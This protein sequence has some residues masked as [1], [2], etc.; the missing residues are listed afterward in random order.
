[1]SITQ[2][3]RN[4]LGTAIVL[5]SSLGIG[6]SSYTEEPSDAINLSE[7]S[8][9]KGKKVIIEALPGQDE[10]GVLYLSDGQNG[11]NILRDEWAGN[12]NGDSDLGMEAIQREVNDGIER[13]IE[14]WGI[15]SDDGLAIKARTAKVY[16]QDKERFV[17]YEVYK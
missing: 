13:K 5:A 3:L 2:R 14:V 11:L 1:M 6:C 9:Y 4:T 16:D 10:K 8:Q 12:H 7:V 17:G 15:V